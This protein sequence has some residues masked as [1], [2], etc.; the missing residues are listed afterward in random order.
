M[1]P[2]RAPREISVH[3]NSDGDHVGISGLLDLI[4]CVSASVIVFREVLDQNT[5]D[6]ES[7]VEKHC[8]KHYDPVTPY[9][10]CKNAFIAGH[11]SRD[12]ELSD[13][14]GKLARQHKEKW[15]F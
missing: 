13:E 2:S 15:K 8:F 11:T 10:S 14:Y 5:V 9:N 4:K 6:F 12:Q 7:I 1:T 3:F